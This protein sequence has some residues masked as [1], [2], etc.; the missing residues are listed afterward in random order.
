M[1]YK[2]IITSI[3][4]RTFQFKIFINFILVFSLTKIIPLFHFVSLEK[5]DVSNNCLSGKFIVM[6]NSFLN[7]RLLSFCSKYGKALFWVDE[8]MAFTN[9]ISIQNGVEQEKF[10]LPS[11]AK[12]EN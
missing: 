9:N 3:I 10:P 12:P 1:L 2:Y 6:Y 4:L 7:N 8:L 5:L 11:Q